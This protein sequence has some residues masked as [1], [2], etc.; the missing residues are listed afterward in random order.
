VALKNFLTVKI[1]KIRPEPNIRDEKAR[2]VG[3]IRDVMSETNGTKNT[4]AL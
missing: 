2:E 3:E 1:S 4:N